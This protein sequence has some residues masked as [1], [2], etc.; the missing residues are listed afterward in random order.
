MANS[1]GRT[2]INGCTASNL[3]KGSFPTLKDMR[4]ISLVSNAFEGISI[5]NA[6]MQIAYLEILHG[7]IINR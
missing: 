5:Q 6:E 3:E 7:D 1:M 2:I 4:Q